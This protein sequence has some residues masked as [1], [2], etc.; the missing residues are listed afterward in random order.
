MYLCKIQRVRVYT[1]TYKHTHTH[2]WE[3]P[4]LAVFLLLLLTA[5]MCMCEY[6]PYKCY[7][8]HSWKLCI[9]VIRC[10]RVCMEKC[11]ELVFAIADKNGEK[12][13]YCKSWIS[14]IIRERNGEK[15]QTK[16]FPSEKQIDVNYPGLWNSMYYSYMNN[17]ELCV[18]FMRF[19]DSILCYWQALEHYVNYT[20]HPYGKCWKTR[21]RLWPINLISLIGCLNMRYFHYIQ[22]NGGHRSN[23]RGRAWFALSHKSKKSMQINLEVR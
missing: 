1:L 23:F 5:N 12:Q 15:S 17:T 22:I 9:I 10:S 7:Y 21:L 18:N 6:K 14:Q 8:C 3:I 11:Q 2:T 4:W 16:R 20:L 19:K 13:K